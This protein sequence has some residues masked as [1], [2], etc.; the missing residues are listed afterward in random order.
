MTLTILLHLLFLVTSFF[1]S[2]IKLFGYKSPQNSTPFSFT[3]PDRAAIVFTSTQKTLAFGVAMIGIIYA[4]D[5][6]I[7]LKSLPLIIY[8][9]SQL[10]IASLFVTKAKVHIDRFFSNTKDW[11]LAGKSDVELKEVN[12]HVLLK[13]ESPSVELEGDT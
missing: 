3:R 12:L 13:Q 10:V 7:G 5:P 1:S 2:G 4:G 9:P 8:H 6:Q 11:V